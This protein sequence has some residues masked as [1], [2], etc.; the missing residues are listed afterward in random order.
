[1]S[2]SKVTKNTFPQP[3]CVLA[4]FVPNLLSKSVWLNLKIDPPSETLDP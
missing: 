1:M 3:P 2:N 4:E